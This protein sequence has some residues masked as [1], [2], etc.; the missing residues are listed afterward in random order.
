[1]AQRKRLGSYCVSTLVLVHTAVRRV[2]R[3]REYVTALP[4]AGV[5][6]PRCRPAG[7]A[8]PGGGY[9]YSRL[10]CLYGL[11]RSM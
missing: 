4:A 6:W 3:V 8:W 9:L 10:D 5:A 11:E 1:M 7:V 2:G